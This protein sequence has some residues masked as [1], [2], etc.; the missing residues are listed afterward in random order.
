MG[1]FERVLRVERNV[2]WALRGPVMKAIVVAFVAVTVAGVGQKSGPQPHE[3]VDVLLA[4]VPDAARA[5]L[6]PLEGDVGSEIAGK[7]LFDRHCAECH[8]EN[9][10]GA[11]RGP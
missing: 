9:G 8:G 3:P 6:N 4:R 7:K 2:S 10:D 1:A 11:K 5:K